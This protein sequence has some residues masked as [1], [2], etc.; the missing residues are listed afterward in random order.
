MHVTN[1]GFQQGK[2]YS[3]MDSISE[4]NNTRNRH[5]SL[6]MGNMDEREMNYRISNQHGEFE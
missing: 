2:L 1:L 4:A 5:N 3:N 6:Y